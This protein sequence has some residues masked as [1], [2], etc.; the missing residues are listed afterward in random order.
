MLPPLKRIDRMALNKEQLKAAKSV[1]RTLTKARDLGLSVRGYD[2]ALYLLNIDEFYAD[3]DYDTGCYAT[4]ANNVGVN[5]L[6]SGIECDFGAG[7]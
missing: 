2:D 5:V 1:K 6:P 4:T 7:N 3:D